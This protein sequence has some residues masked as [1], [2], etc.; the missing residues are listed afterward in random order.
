MKAKVA[1]AGVEDEKFETIEPEKRQQHL[2]GIPSV[3]EIRQRA[4]EIHLE[5]G[6]AHGWDQDDWLLAE[7]DLAKK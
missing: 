6:G 5:R 1:I 2:A 4:Y 7:R 3:E